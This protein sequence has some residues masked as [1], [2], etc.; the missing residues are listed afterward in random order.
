VV[1]HRSG[2]ISPD[3]CGE[4]EYEGGTGRDKDF[5]RPF[6][7]GYVPLI[8]NLHSGNGISGTPSNGQFVV[9]RRFLQPFDWAAQLFTV[10]RPE[11]LVV[12][13]INLL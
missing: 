5:S 7:S 2:S 9:L 10:H 3:Y 6:Y 8:T 12:I 11:S 1:L 4:L 13:L